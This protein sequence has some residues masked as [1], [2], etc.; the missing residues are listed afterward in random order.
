M[1]TYTSPGGTVPGLFADML[2]QPHLLIAG[3]S[4][5]GK[6]VLINGL[7]CATLRYHRCQALISQFPVI[8]TI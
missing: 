1:T 3:A 5:S 6:S 8:R 7:I 4:G 2:S